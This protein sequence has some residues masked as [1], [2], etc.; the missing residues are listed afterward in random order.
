MPAK[1]PHIVWTIATAAALVSCPE[2][3]GN[4]L[5]FMGRH[6]GPIGAI[7]LERPITYASDLPPPEPPSP[8]TGESVHNPDGTLGWLATTTAPSADFKRLVS[9]AEAAKCSVQMVE[10]EAHGVCTGGPDIVIRMNDSTV[11][12]LCIAD[13]DRYACERLWT[14]IG[15]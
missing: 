6:G 11:S 7:E 15:N 13:S 1:A 12:K 3:Q 14:R 5:V 8:V 4:R 9:L 10:S 2:R